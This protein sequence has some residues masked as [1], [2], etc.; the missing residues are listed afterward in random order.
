MLF[1]LMIRRPPRST[2]FPYTTL[3]RSYDLRDREAVRGLFQT[4]CPEVVLH[5]AAVVGGIGAN[6]SNPGRF[7]FDN[8]I[9]GLQVMEEARPFG[10]AKFVMV[11]TVCSYPQITPVPFREEDLW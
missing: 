4:A 5:L 7:F 8:A 6:R 9:M 2:L 10:V 11:G 1:F 3:F